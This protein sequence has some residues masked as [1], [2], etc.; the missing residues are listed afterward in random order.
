MVFTDDRQISQRIFQYLGNEDLVALSTVSRTL[1]ERAEHTLYHNINLQDFFDGERVASWCL[2]ILCES[3]RAHQVNILRFPSR[4]KYAPTSNTSLSVPML[5][6]TIKRTFRAMINLKELFVLGSARLKDEADT[7]NS[8]LP[9]TFNNCEF[10]LSGFAGQLPEFPPEDV[11]K[12]LAN[13]PDITYWVPDH[14][15]LLSIPSFPLTILPNLREVVLVRPELTFCLEG[16]PIQALTLAF[17]Q[18]VHT[19]DDGLEAITALKVFKETLRTLV[20]QYPPNILDWNLGDIVRAIAQ[21]APNLRTLTLNCFF[22]KVSM[23][24]VRA[25]QI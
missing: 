13:H 25:A 11:W 2:A 1:Q 23:V 3:R 7:I 5:H 15:L 19:R 12:L 22:A 9:S 24:S 4:L 17:I 20:Y 8:I 6:S 18:P 21:S 16:R 14:P 10:R